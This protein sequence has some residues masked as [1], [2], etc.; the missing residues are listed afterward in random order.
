[1]EDNNFP[2]TFACLCGKED[3][4][5]TKAISNNGL[6]LKYASTQYKNN[7]DIVLKAVTQNGL[8]LKFA[9]TNLRKDINV[10]REAV[11]NNAD[12]LAFAL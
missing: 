5:V 12:S 4:I 3:L 9:D 11:K 6:A 2:H 10:I 8:A 1:M 7:I